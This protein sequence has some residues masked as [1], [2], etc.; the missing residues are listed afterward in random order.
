MPSVKFLKEPEMRNQIWIELSKP[1][2]DIHGMEQAKL[3]NN[4]L[5]RLAD[6]A[7]LDVYFEYSDGKYHF[8]N[9]MGTSELADN[10]RWFN[11]NYLGRG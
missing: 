1:K 2:N 5:R 11:L 4:M 6:G 8:G 10:G 7:P 9:C 3:A